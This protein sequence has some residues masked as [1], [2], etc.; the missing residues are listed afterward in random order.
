MVYC[1]VAMDMNR[2]IEMKIMT[3]KLNVIEKETTVENILKGGQYQRIKQQE[4]YT[5]CKHLNLDGK[6]LCHSRFCIFTVGNSAH[7][8]SDNVYRNIFC[9]LLCTHHFHFLLIMKIS[10]LSLMLWKTMGTRNIEKHRM[11]CEQGTNDE[12]LMNGNRWTKVERRE[13]W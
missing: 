2:K 11:L 1:T 12:H 10:P 4:R 5:S 9:Y 3:I 6:I 8:F 13:K 7:V